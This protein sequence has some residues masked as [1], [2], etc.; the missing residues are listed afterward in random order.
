MKICINGNGSKTIK[1]LPI[2]NYDVIQTDWSWRYT[3]D[4]VTKTAAVND[5]A[6]VQA[7]FTQTMSDT[8]WLDGNGYKD[9]KFAE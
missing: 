5:T 7:D 8:R 3:P 6:P 4:A 2:G 9:N 1:N